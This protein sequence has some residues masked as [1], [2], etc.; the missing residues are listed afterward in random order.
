MSMET[1][2]KEIS[3]EIYDFCKE[4]DHSN[5]PLFIEVEPKE[6]VRF[7]YCLT[8]VA[9]YVKEKGGSEVFGWIIWECPKVFLN[10]QFHACWKKP[11]DT[12]VDIVPKPDKEKRILF[13]ADSKRVYQNKLVDNKRKPLL[14]NGYTRFWQKN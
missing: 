12:L 6:N 11:N 10:A 1:T 5:K 13:L 9:R 2:P 14:N 3:K 8:D 7:N 4:I